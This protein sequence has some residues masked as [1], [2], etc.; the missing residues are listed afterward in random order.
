MPYRTF[1]ATTGVNRPVGEKNH[2]RPSRMAS[3]VYLLWS[4]VSFKLILAQLMPQRIP[5]RVFVSKPCFHPEAFQLIDLLIHGA[6]KYPVFVW[7][8]VLPWQR[9]YGHRTKNQCLVWRNHNLG[10]GGGG[11][12]WPGAGSGH[13]GHLPWRWPYRKN[14][15]GN[16]KRWPCERGYFWYRNTV[17]AYRRRKELACQLKV[18]R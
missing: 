1:E 7:L 6:Q 4:T 3:V 16:N 17:C 10:G 13:S 5:K 14:S 2:K 8:K 9:F 12:V 11:L 15:F 18:Q